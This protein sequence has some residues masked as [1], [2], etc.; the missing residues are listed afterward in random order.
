MR[1]LGLRKL[2]TTSTTMGLEAEPNVRPSE[3]M[4]DQPV[5][6]RG[7]TTRPSLS[8]FKSRFKELEGV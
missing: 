4:N 6:E 1:N 8:F 2:F 5:D 7:C 3:K